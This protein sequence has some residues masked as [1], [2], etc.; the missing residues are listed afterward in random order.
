MRTPK[1]VILL[2]LCVIA[3]SLL[4]TSWFS[5]KHVVYFFELCVTFVTLF[6][7]GYTILGHFRYFSR[8]ERVALSFGVSV[9]VLVLVTLLLVALGFTD[10]LT[11]L[12]A[13]T[14]VI[15]IAAVALLKRKIE[16]P[17][18]VGGFP[19]AGTFIFILFAAAFVALPVKIGD[20]PFTELETFTRVPFLGGDHMMYYNYAVFL[21][22]KLDPTKIRFWYNW[23][24]TD[25]TPLQGIL[26][27]FFLTSYGASVPVSTGT[28][29]DYALWGGGFASSQL[30]SLLVNDFTGIWIHRSTA[31]VCNSSLLVPAFFLA[32]SLFERR[33]AKIAFSVMLASPWSLAMAIYG[34]PVPMATYFVLVAFY[35][36]LN[37]RSASLSGAMIGLGYLAHPQT[38]IYAIGCSVY[39]FWRDRASGF[40]KSFR[41]FFSGGRGYFGLAILI[42]LPWLVWSRFYAGNVPSLPFLLM[43]LDVKGYLIFHNIHDP[44]EYQVIVDT[45]LHTPPAEI[46][47][48][49]VINVARTLLNI[50]L[51][52]QL[53]FPK[54]G[55]LSPSWNFCFQHIRA[56][57]GAVPF[58]FAPVAYYGALRFCYRKKK[59]FV[60]LL[61]LPFILIASLNGYPD[62]SLVIMGMDF[63]IILIIIA[64]AKVIS[65]TQNLLKYLYPLIFLEYGLVVWFSFYKPGL[66]FLYYDN[67]LQLGVAVTAFTA[68]ALLGY[69]SARTVWGDGNS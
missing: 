44:S 12:A 34:R 17:L 58:A 43:P 55:N 21:L 18:L 69:V 19:L 38:L 10:R 7:P 20:L 36:L 22:H 59:E 33:T 46:L 48:V 24:I 31:I 30:Q 16:S 61:I 8:D 49:R 60:S 66:F 13:H 64:G 65:Q 6:L 68:F 5:L 53:V 62:Y 37:H 39:L 54:W 35:L 67:P 51:A 50:E 32:K 25:R 26:E 23:Y 11:F 14:L 9:A 45:F 56:L 2:G 27:A 57:T 15:T 40:T 4:L 52:N 1:N 3:T 47:F 28:D 63:I 29:A 41:R 42:A